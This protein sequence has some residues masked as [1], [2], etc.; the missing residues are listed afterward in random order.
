MNSLAARYGLVIAAG[1]VAVLFSTSLPALSILRQHLMHFQNCISTFFQKNRI[2]YKT[3]YF[4]L[5]ENLQN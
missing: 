1:L 4:F 3:K 5:S 2:F